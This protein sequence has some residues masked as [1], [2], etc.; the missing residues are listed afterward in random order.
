MGSSRV[1]ATSVSTGSLKFLATV[2]SEVTCMNQSV[3]MFALQMSHHA[4]TDVSRSPISTGTPE[5]PSQRE[6]STSSSSSGSPLRQRR[7]WPV[8]RR[9]KDMAALAA[10]PALLVS[11]A[12]RLKG[13]GEPAH[14]GRARCS[15]AA[16]GAK[17]GATVR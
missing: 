4:E 1:P 14:A 5:E 12:T 3:L 15:S 9:K 11:T 10:D 2:K 13:R 7:K 17:Q 8:A 16:C 6:L